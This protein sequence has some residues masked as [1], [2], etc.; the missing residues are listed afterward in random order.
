MLG[1]GRRKKEDEEMKKEEQMA[2]TMEETLNSD[3]DE[4]D[5]TEAIELTP[6]ELARQGAREQKRFL[7]PAKMY[8]RLVTCANLKRK[9]GG[10]LS[11]SIALTTE[12]IRFMVIHCREQRRDYRARRRLTELV[13]KRRRLLDK[14]AWSDVDTYIT[15]REELKIRHVYRFQALIGRLREYKY[16]DEHRKPQPGFKA[17]MRIKNSRKLWERRVASAKR[18]G[19]PVTPMM[20]KKAAGLKWRVQKDDEV[21][22]LISGKATPEF[23]DPLDLP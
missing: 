21:K 12:Y 3:F 2:K 9:Y 23:F 14:L 6:L 15:L 13:G 17:V 1:L 16:F 10:G 19:K 4:D 5:Q 11:Y 20:T 8:Q 22:Y 18:T 7:Y